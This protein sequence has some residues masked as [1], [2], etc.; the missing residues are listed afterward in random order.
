ME[1]H[2]KTQ[3]GGGAASSCR[4]VVRYI[5]PVWQVLRMTDL[6]DF[7]L[8][9]LVV[10]GDMVLRCTYSDHDVLSSLRAGR[11]CRW[12]PWYCRRMDGLARM[13]R[14]SFLMM[15]RRFDDD[16]SFQNMCMWCTL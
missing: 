12:V 9:R 10:L 4:Q 8:C 11:W 15:G 7:N 13:L 3:A 16:D 5:M 2:L 1:Q 6:P 14:I